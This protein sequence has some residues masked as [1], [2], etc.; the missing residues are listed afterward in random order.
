MRPYCQS[1]HADLGLVDDDRTED[2]RPNSRTAPVCPVF[3][4][5]AGTAHTYQLA[6]RK[7]V[8]PIMAHRD[9]P[10]EQPCRTCSVPT[11]RAAGICV[12]CADY[13]PPAST[14]AGRGPD[15]ASVCPLEFTR[16]LVA[17]ARFALL[18][19]IASG[20]LS[21]TAAVD[22]LDALD[23]LAAADKLISRADEQ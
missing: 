1:D 23:H 22:L 2:M 21:P 13:E 10:A 6:Q 17:T 12:F 7:Q 5:P 14:A 9:I 18:D 20:D 4:A 8:E 3:A 15:D 16:G 19:R 11:E